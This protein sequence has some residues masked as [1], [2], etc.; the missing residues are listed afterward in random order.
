M[1]PP[2]RIMLGLAAVAGVA[3]I[4]TI[5]TEPDPAPMMTKSEIADAE[6]GIVTRPNPDGTVSFFCE[7]CPTFIQGA[8]D[9][10]ATPTWTSCDE[11]WEPVSRVD[12]TPMCAQNLQ[13]PKERGR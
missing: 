5:R 4:V 7:T 6:R 11:G 12:G 9:G 13:H 3:A 8:S 2:V 10:A 1:M